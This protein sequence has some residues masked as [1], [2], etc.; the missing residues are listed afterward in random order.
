MK[1]VSESSSKGIG[2]VVA[3]LN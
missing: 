3:V 2:K 1:S